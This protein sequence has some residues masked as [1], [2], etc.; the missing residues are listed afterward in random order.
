[1]VNEVGGPKARIAPIASASSIPDEVAENYVEAFGK[2]GPRT[3]TTC[4][5]A[6]GRK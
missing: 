4:G 1:M 2:L 5:C 6:T 3:W